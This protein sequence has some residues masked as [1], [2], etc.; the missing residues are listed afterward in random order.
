MGG[1]VL[2]ESWLGLSGLD[3][4]RLTRRPGSSPGSYSGLLMG[5]AFRYSP[6]PGGI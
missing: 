4:N 6:W 2:Y 3:M 1:Q 5:A